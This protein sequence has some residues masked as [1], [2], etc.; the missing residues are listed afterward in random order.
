M[1]KSRLEAFSDGVLAIIITIMVLE[2]R[3]PEGIGW[4]DLL[5][6]KDVFLCYIS[7]FVIVGIYWAN[8]HHLLHTVK[9][10]RGGMLWANLNLLFWLSL[11]PFATA[12]M[13]ENHFAKNTVITYTIL[14]DICGLA[15][16]ILLTVIKKCNPGND[17]LTIVLQKQTKKGL[18]S[19]V[20]NTLSVI[21]AFFHPAIGGFFLLLV[22]LMWLIPDRNIER[23]V[24][25]N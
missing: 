4:S 5:K 19:N 25:E 24:K 16:F 1:T 13:G 21:G 9:D 18:I 10:V 14:A 7:S 11:I 2:M 3:K 6:L 12:W 23:A 15:Y 22:F 8:H 17:E 20:F